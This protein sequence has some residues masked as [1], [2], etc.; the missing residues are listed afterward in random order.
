MAK[1]KKA[2]SIMWRVRQCNERQALAGLSVTPDDADFASHENRF[3]RALNDLGELVW[4][5]W[6]SRFGSGW[7][8]R[9]FVQMFYEA[10]Y[11]PVDGPR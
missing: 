7:A 6:S 3:I 4:M 10:G 8:L 2:Q 5:P 11:K 1:T 9:D